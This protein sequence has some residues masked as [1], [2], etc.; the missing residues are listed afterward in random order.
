[1]LYSPCTHIVTSVFL[2]TVMT[3]TVIPQNLK[4]DIGKRT[5]VIPK[6]CEAVIP[7]S[8][9]DIPELIKEVDCRGAGDMLVEY[10]YETKVITRS[11]DKKGAVKEESTTYEVY[12]P[13]LKE[14]MRAR[15]ILLETARNGVP[16]PEKELE[17]ERQKAGEKLEKEDSKAAEQP[18]QEPKTDAAPIKGPTKGMIP[19]GMY[20]RMGTSHSV[21]GIKKSGTRLS[22]ATVLRTC[23]FKFL[24]RAQNEGR[25]VLV[26]SFT[27]RANVQFGADEKY[28]AQLVGE[29]WIDA[30]DHI[31]SK[32][33]GWPVNAANGSESGERPPAV[34]AEMLRLPSGVWLPL[35]SRING[36]DYPKLFNGMVDD[37]SMTHREY[38]QFVTDVKRTK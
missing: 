8:P 1:M 2:L 15:G 5:V 19:I 11:K 28:I 23:D 32:L 24:R 10:T 6:V 37:T 17:K 30:A 33:T 4:V 12:I 16:V 9:E 3:S 38:K 21:M 25:D 31:V 13:T 34:Y 22:V 36:L 18:D 7:A 26:F 29:I 14:G 20:T 27:P 35:A